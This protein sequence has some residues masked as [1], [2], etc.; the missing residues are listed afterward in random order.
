MN[1]NYCKDA[2]LSKNQEIDTPNAVTWGL[3]PGSEVS[4]PTVIDP[5]AFFAWKEEAFQ[6]W[7][8]WAQ[9]YPKN[10]ESYQYLSQI[11]SKVYLISLVDNNHKSRYALYDLLEDCA[12]IMRK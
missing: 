4:Q 2:D 9:L 8:E 12:T 7:R 10:S 11:A 1:D 6:I 3:F 5:E